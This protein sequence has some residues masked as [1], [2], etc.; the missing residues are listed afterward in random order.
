VVTAPFHSRRFSSVKLLEAMARAKPV[1]ATELG[2]QREIIRDGREGFLVPPGDVDRLA[3]RILYCLDHPEERRRLGRQ[4]R[5]TARRH[6]V[7]SVVA[8][9]EDWYRQLAAG[10]RRRRGR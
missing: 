2:E 7:T 4:A 10:N 6:S 1:V 3:E 8:E 9:L 5:E